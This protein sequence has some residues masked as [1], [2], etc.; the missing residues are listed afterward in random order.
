MIDQVDAASD[1]VTVMGLT[2]HVTENTQ[3]AGLDGNPFAL[4]EL[5]A[6]DRISLT[7]KINP[8]GRRFATEIIRKPEGGKSKIEGPIERV[9]ELGAGLRS[10]TVLGMDV[11]IDDNID[12]KP[13]R[14]MPSQEKGSPLSR[15]F[16][17][18]FLD[19]QRELYDIK[20]DPGET[21]NLVDERPNI[22]Q[23]LEEML[24]TWSQSLLSEAPTATSHV[25]VDPETLEQLRRM[26][27]VD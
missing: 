15:V 5:V 17:G 25:D 1:T 13:L 7:F 14:R 21:R 16:M 9:Q 2:C 18:D 24:S 8:D 12:V 3:C 23:E 10:L 27:Y 11:T 20:L 19:V 6:G 4:G 26:G 22:A